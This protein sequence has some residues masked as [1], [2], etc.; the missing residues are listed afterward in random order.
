MSDLDLQL[1]RKVDIPR[2]PQAAVIDVVDAPQGTKMFS[3]FARFTCPEFTSLCPV[4][5]QPDFGIMV[6]DYL[7]EAKLIESKALKL[8]LASFRNHKAFHEACTVMI[9]AKLYAAAQPFWLRCSSFW[10]PRGG[11]TI[12]CV[13][14]CGMRPEGA[15]V[16]PIDISVYGARR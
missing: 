4:T 12:D 2:S 3:T 14:D 13:H 8:F 9:A 15:Y 5:H 6:I 11:I 7:P 16:P 10:Y 1:G